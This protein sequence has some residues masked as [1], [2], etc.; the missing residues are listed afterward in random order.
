METSSTPLDLIG[1]FTDYPNELVF[2]LFLSAVV[3]FL[4]HHYTRG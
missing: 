2:V 1:L 3:A 4:V